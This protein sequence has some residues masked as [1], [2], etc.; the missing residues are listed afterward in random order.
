MNVKK[1]VKKIAALGAGAVLVGAT[2][3]GA[4]ATADLGAY[5]TPFI[6]DNAYNAKIVVGVNAATMDVIGA[7][8]IAAGLQALSYVEEIVTTED[9]TTVV[10]DGVVEDDLELGDAFAGDEYNDGDIS[11][12]ADDNVRYNAEDYEYEETILIADNAIIPSSSEANNDYVNVMIEVDE[13]N[14]LCYEY[15]FDDPVEALTSANGELVLDFL[16]LDLTITEVDDN[17]VTLSAA[18]ET[19]LNHGETL[20]VEIS[21]EEYTIE[22]AS[23]YD[24]KAIFKVNG[25]TES[26]T[27]D[28]T[29][30]FGFVDFE[31]ELLGAYNDDG[32]ENDAVNFKYGSTTSETATDAAAAEMLGYGDDDDEAEWVWDIAST[33]TDNN[34]TSIGVCYNL[35]RNEIEA[36]LDEDWQ[37]P[38]LAEGDEIVFPNDFASV[39]FVAVNNDNGYGSVTIEYDDSV[40]FTSDETETGFTSDDVWVIDADA[41][42]LSYDSN[43]YEKIYVDNA[44]TGAATVR[45]CMVD[46]NN[47]KD[48]DLV[49]GNATTNVDD[50]SIKVDDDLINIEFDFATNV[51]NITIEDV[52]EWASAGTYNGDIYYL[53][54]HDGEADDNDLKVDGLDIQGFDDNYLTDYG[55]IIETPEDNLDNGD[56]GKLVLQ[57]P[58]DQLTVDIAFAA[59]EAVGGSSNLVTKTPV[60]ITNVAVLD[61]ETEVG[62]TNLIVIGGPCANSIANSLMA[63]AVCNEG[64]S[65]G[66]GLIKMWETGDFMAVLVAGYEAADTLA[67]VDVLVHYDDYV[68]EF[69][70]NSEVEI[71]TATKEV[72]EVT[73]VPDV[74]EP[75]VEEP[76]VEEPEV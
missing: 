35:D 51:V 42:I 5:P 55:V 23:I 59:S 50:I 12:L 9:G 67:A 39:Q 22:A 16:G 14:N 21:G 24:D 28:G 6:T 54:D 62:E 52:A 40:T 53:A 57:V 25:V 37:M 31:I 73:V 10:E 65:Q 64:F 19:W 26:I 4:V 69:T 20:T 7:T 1:V 34:L 38:A 18:T 13:G 36:E 70:G 61:T 3:L 45:I 33:A 15:T 63:N 17:E 66:K 27:E 56:Y 71:T 8:D 46:S 2:I 43:E 47:N 58:D 44:I 68:E 60:P 49:V 30:D 72:T 76:E 74:E 32:T 29:E 11:V 75:E 41:E 48:C